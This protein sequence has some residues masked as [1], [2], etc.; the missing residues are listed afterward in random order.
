MK[1]PQS[2]SLVVTMPKE[3]NYHI[4]EGYY[5]GHVHMVEPVPRHNCRDCEN[6]VRIFFALKV[7]GKDKFLNLAKAEMPIDVNHGSELRE[8]LTRLL[9][10]ETVEAMAGK[11]SDVKSLLIGRPADVEVE[12]IITSKSDQYDFPFVKVCAIQPPGTFVAIKPELAKESPAQ[13][14]TPEAM[15]EK[16]YKIEA[17]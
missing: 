14:S 16:G 8:V 2:K 7:P 1:N 9:G 5:T 4:D 13:S 12:H 3:R 11:K 17:K 6:N 15:Q 10:K